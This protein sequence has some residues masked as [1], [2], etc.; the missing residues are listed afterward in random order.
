MKK[1]LLLLAGLGLLLPGC[2]TPKSDANF[3]AATPASVAV[4]RVGVT[5][6]MPPMIYL[7][8]GEYHGMDADLARQFAATLGKT[9]QFVNVPWTEQIDALLAGRT[10]IIISSMSVTA[11]RAMRISFTDSYLR[12][13]QTALVR[14]K[15]ANSIQFELYGRKYRVGAQRGTTGEYFVQ[16]QLPRSDLKLYRD[17]RDG[18]EALLGGVLGPDIDVFV[19]DAPMNWYLASEYEDRGLTVL[20]MMLTEEY[21]AWGVGRNDLVLRDAANRFIAGIKADGKLQALIK[22][23]LPLA[24]AQ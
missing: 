4:L 7:Q 22:R 19:N 8:N 18:A 6:N 11:A 21:L 24:T 2:T 9:V 1:N 14:R 5:P 16:S 17:A 23:W 15:D 20:P 3:A 10:D 13:G 12:S